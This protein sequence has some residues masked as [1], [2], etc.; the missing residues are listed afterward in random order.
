MLPRSVANRQLVALWGNLGFKTFE[1][2]ML[3]NWTNDA[4]AD[5]ICTGQPKNSSGPHRITL[6][7][8]LVRSAPRSAPALVGL[9]RPGTSS[10]DVGE[11]RFRLRIKRRQSGFG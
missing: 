6:I 3:L 2:I 5:E 7:P 10:Y 4:E 9:I 8:G 1:E 11:T